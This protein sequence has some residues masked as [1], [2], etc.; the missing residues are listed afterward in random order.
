MK[1]RS[2]PYPFSV[3]NPSSSNLAAQQQI[4]SDPP[5]HIHPSFI[6]ACC[7]TID[8]SIHIHPSMEELKGTSKEKWKRD[9][10][11]P[12]IHGSFLQIQQC[13]DWMWADSPNGLMDASI[14]CTVDHG[15]TSESKLGSN[16]DCRS[17][18]EQ[19]MMLPSHK[20]NHQQTN[21]REKKRM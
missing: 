11:R 15:A 16:Q 6:L 18:K 10:N 12:W 17:N 21:I 13:I 1:L 20:Q 9:G 19:S 2:P 8:P 5:R 3:F 4:G 14:K 7:Y